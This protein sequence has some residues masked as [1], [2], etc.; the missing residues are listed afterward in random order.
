MLECRESTTL[1]HG[2]F[3]V[4]IR[5]LYCIK[6]LNVISTVPT[7]SVKKKYWYRKQFPCC[8]FILC[9]ER[10]KCVNIAFIGK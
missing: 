6:T 2:Q 5:V 9:Q 4:A 10:K 7:T 3:G 8:P 1:T